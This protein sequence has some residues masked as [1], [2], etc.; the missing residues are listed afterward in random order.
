MKIILCSANGAVRERWF[1]ILSEQRLSLYQ[2][3]SIKTLATLIHRNEQYLLLV[4]QQF[5]DV[6]TIGTLCKTPGSLRIFFL[7]DAPNSDEG[8]T[9]LLMGA[10]GY[11]NTY[12][13]GGRL[14]EAIKTVV[15]GRVWFEQETIRQFIRQIK[16][17][18]NPVEKGGIGGGILDEL[19]GREKEIA[20][21]VVEGLSNQEIGEKLFISERTVKAHL[22]SIF[23]KT[24]TKS[25]LDLAM[26]L[27]RRK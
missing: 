3:S 26:K 1:S 11:A 14:V 10:A 27:Q 15:A 7:S 21:L 16:R 17:G 25:R 4:H 13:A 5:T 2:A 19:S 8:L 6:Q 18:A 20:L 9:F 23:R 22:S 12:I 24:G